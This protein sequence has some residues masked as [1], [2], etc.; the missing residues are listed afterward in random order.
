MAEVIA[1]VGI[2][3]SFI[4][5]V[6]FGS[7]VAERLTEFVAHNKD[8][9]QSFRHIATE[10]PVLLVMLKQSA[11]AIEKNN[12]TDETRQAL[13]TPVKECGAEIEALL[14]LLHKILPEPGH[15]KKARVW[16]GVLSLRYDAKV[17]NKMAV[18]RNY[19]ATLSSYHV[20][21]LSMS[22]Y[23]TGESMN[24]LGNL[25][26]CLTMASQL[27]SALYQSLCHRLPSQS[28][29]TPTLSVVKSYTKLGRNLTTLYPVLS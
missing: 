17:K 10:L 19:A 9:P 12:I 13:S 11:Q 27:Q 14:K 29:V 2:I 4:Q 8:V 22:V 24:L 28:T 16:K 26:L 1:V 20:T 21:F 25:L 7:K 3:A 6:D 15:T 18:I 23:T 5:L